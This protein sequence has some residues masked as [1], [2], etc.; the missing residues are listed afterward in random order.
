MCNFA[1]L[2][3]DKIPV[4]IWFDHQLPHAEQHVSACWLWPVECGST[5][6]Q[7]LC[8]VAGYWQEPDHTVINADPEHSNHAQ[9]VMG[10]DEEEVNLLDAEVL[11]CCGYTCSVLVRPAG[12]PVMLSDTHLR[13]LMVEKWAFVSWAT[14][15]VD[16]PAFSIPTAGSL[17]TSGFGGTALGDQP[18]RFRVACYCGQSKAHLCNNNAV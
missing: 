12:R 17:K 14:A 7:W 2:G 10:V 3:G 6:L 15:L 18:A 5:A 11:G 8:Q 13:R 16:I 4:S 9:W 1:L